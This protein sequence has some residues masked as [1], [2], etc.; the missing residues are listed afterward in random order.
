MFKFYFH[1][2]WSTKHHTENQALQTG[3]KLGAPE[4]L[5]A[6]APLVTS[7]VLFLLQIQ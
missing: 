5:A 7:V 6:P 4:M 2:Q 3:V 1:K